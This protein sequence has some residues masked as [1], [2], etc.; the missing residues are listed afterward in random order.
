[1]RTKF[2]FR[3]VRVAILP[4]DLQH[5]QIVKH[6]VTAGRSA[7]CRG[8]SSGQQHFTQP[9]RHDTAHCSPAQPNPA[10]QHTQCGL[11]RHSTAQHSTAQHSTAQHSTAQRSTAQ[12]SA[13]QR[14]T[15]QHSTAQLTGVV[16][17]FNMSELCSMLSAS[18]EMHSNLV[19]LPLVCCDKMY[20]LLTGHIKDIKMMSE[21]LPTMTW[22]PLE[23]AVLSLILFIIL[24]SPSPCIVSVNMSGIYYATRASLEAHSCLHNAIQ[25][26]I[27]A[28][29]HQSGYKWCAAYSASNHMW[30]QQSDNQNSLCLCSDASFQ[31]Q[32]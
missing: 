25:Q 14:S 29:A 12:R 2:S 24:V 21:S 32:V 19:D 3:A 13:A 4:Y 18:I 28:A 10:E 6:S 30:W 11:A 16:A 1:M 23:C 31:G 20:S 22:L 9:V 27:A 7:D 15:A 26:C 5:R 8:S 17:A